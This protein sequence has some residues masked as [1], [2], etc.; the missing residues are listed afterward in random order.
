MKNV[1]IE[2]DIS[3]SGD[4]EIFINDTRVLDLDSTEDRIVSEFIVRESQVRY[5]YLHFPKKTGL[6]EHIK[7]GRDIVINYENKI[8]NVKNYE[9]TA[10]RIN[11]LNRFF[12]ENPEIKED[13]KLEIELMTEKN[14]LELNIRLLSK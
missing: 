2:I 6:Q 1:K 7:N 11:G 14:P 13:D 4:N 3:I 8:Y 10:G 9:P 12:Q 5:G